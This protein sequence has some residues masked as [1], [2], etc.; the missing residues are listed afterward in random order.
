VNVQVIIAVACLALL[1]W[2]GPADAQQTKTHFLTVGHHKDVQISDNDVKKI[3]AEASKTL[4]KCKVVLKLKGSVGTF[5][6]T[7]RPVTVKDAAS[8]DAVHKE[9]FDVKIVKS[10]TFCRVDEL[11]GVGCAWDPPPPPAEQRPQHRSIIVG[12][13]RVAQLTGRIWAHEFG[14]TRGLQHRNERNALMGCKVPDRGDAQ[15]SD[16]ECECFRGGPGD[17]AREPEPEGQ[18]AMQ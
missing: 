14:H 6:S 7:D 18:C 12:D 10:I 1:F 8:R 4:R 15:I 2:V 3:L 9:N 17:C 11:M 16:K 5:G 13:F